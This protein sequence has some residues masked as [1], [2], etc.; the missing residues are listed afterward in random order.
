[1]ITDKSKA[2]ES[3]TMTLAKRLSTKYMEQKKWSE[4]TS[5]IR[6]TLQRT[7]SSF[8]S[9]SVHDVTLT[10]TFLQES[11][12]VVQ[13]LAECY[14]EQRQ[15]EKAEDVYLRLFRAVLVSKQSDNTLLDKVKW[16]LINFYD[17]HGYP[18][19]AISTFQD[20]LVV[21]RKTYG[22]S[23]ETTIQTLYA[24][25]SRCRD[26]A[27]SHPYWIE[28]YQQIVTSLN[29]DS[30]VCHVN[31]MEA[32]TIVA[33]SYWEE[34][35][36]AEAVQVFAVLWNTFFRK[37]SEYKQFSDTKLVQVLYERYFQCLEETR[38]DWELLYRV[39]TEYRETCSKKFGA[40]S[41]LTVEATLALARVSQK[42]EKH[43]SQAISL[44][45]EVS[46]SSS[47]TSVSKTE[48]EQ[49][50]STLYIR[51]ITSQSS[52]STKT[53]T[54]ERATS[55]YL[56]Q[57]SEMKSKYG[58]SHQMTLNHL[59]ELSVLYTKQQKTELAVK[60][61][62]NAVVQINK[63]ETSS[64]KMLESGKFIAETF[65]ACNQVQRCRELV[66]ELHRQI[67]A[68]DTRHAS[69]WS[70]D[71]KNC[72]RASL[73]FLAALEYHTR[74]DI[75]VTFSEIMA[76]IIAEAVY[77][78][79]FRRAMKA[80][81][82]LDKIV[83]AAAPLRW[84]LVKRNLNDFVATLE[85]EIVQLFIQ[86]DITQLKLLSKA[87]PRIF[88]VAILEHLG[89]RKSKNF[90]RSVILA[91]NDRVAVLTK[92]KKFPEAY[93]VANCAFIFA[94]S[95]DGYSGPKAIGHGFKLASCIVGRDGERCPDEGLRKQMLQLSNRIVKEI[96]NICKRTKINFAQVQLPELN[97]LVVLLGEQE[98]YETL[99]VRY[100]IILSGVVIK[101][102]T[103][104]SGSLLHSGVHAT[105]NAL[106]LL[107]FFSILVAASFALATSPV[108][109]SRPFVFAKILPTICV[110]SMA[111][112]I[113]PLW[114]PILC[115][116]NCIPAPVN[117]TRRMP[118]PT[119][120]LVQLPTSI[121]R[122]PC[123]CMRIY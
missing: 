33:N 60:E 51:Q 29:K 93:D 40:T 32:I 22:S 104:Y 115:S 43:S 12:E 91:S 27:R 7:W 71:L 117:T 62:V 81:E 46:K 107:R 30:D 94:V 14:L 118:L 28:Y 45:E 57:F 1:M 37:T 79:K 49:T 69:K 92:T 95:H 61:L 77:Y 65:H 100:Q 84:F 42:S 72:G 76:D 34:R 41:S 70:F 85:D 111:L 103:T 56:E 31:A 112:A 23:H 73:V 102:L 20:V 17:K 9:A 58:Y 63:H 55:I 39:T 64:Q 10:S 108:T 97:Q 25:G 50:L 44:Y 114:K 119:R 82:D 89:N 88:I 120:V 113:Q 3:T 11:I 110:G 2:I 48:I 53:E 16:L 86:R 90:V 13:R 106:G 18:D 21:Y 109:L 36:Y 19:R 87:S 121:S 5:I 80:N 15:I 24:L 59:Q 68:K 123:S 75:S 6:S 78:E 99:E 26:H 52:T 4:A 66:L 8:L 122:R 74:T 101:A 83:L 38:A 67:I 47:S 116:L 54:I 96:L 105:P 98:D 35:R